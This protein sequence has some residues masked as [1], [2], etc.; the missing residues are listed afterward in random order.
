MATDINQIVTVG[1]LQSYDKKIKTAYKDADTA[2]ETKLMDVIGKI[3]S[4]E[5]TIVESLP[6]TGVIGTF[7]LIKADPGEY[8]GANN[9]YKEYLWYMKKE[10]DE[11][12]GTPAEYSW[13][14]VGDTKLDLD[15]L[16]ADITDEV[17]GTYVK[18]VD[19]ST[20]DAT[21]GAVTT[22]TSTISF[23]NGDG[24]EID[25]E[26][27]SS[28]TSIG[29]VVADA[30]GVTG[31]DGLMSKEDKAILDS[32]NDDMGN[33]IRTEDADA[34][35]VAT[36]DAGTPAI[37]DNGDGSK[38]VTTTY[39]AKASDG[40]ELDTFDV[41]GTTYVNAQSAVEADPE[42]GIEGKDAVGG[43]LSAEDKVK[44]DNMTGNADAKYVA[45]LDISAGVGPAIIN[46]NTY[47]T[48]VTVSAKNANGDEID[49]DTF[50]VTTYGEATQE[51][52]GLM[53]AADK[54]KLDGLNFADLGDVDDWFDD[55]W[56]DD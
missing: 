40:T 45:S 17:A 39:T 47:I 51:A 53:S 23:K 32:L 21:V 50:D 7:Y 3:N 1:Y 49:S 43:L 44:I 56:P 2:L 27:I 46:G 25:S 41:L 55:N 29:A 54:I 24:D 22:T 18:S 11:S 9:V 33:F 14:L 8:N 48:T 4:F 20:G 38:T 12:A 26:T 19:V 30:K 36:I 35:Y 31:Y 13:E 6:V 34:K 37:V 28:I 5:I 15:A 10:A 16:K 52:E 42:N